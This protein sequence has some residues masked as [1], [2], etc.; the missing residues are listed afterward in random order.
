MSLV[1]NST[2]A[3]IGVQFVTGMIGV[4]AL[5]VPLPPEH[6]VLRDLLLLETVVQFVELT[7]YIVIVARF[8]LETMAATRYFDWVIT[9]PVML[10]TTVVF[11]AYSEVQEL[12][13][14][15]EHKASP[16]KLESFLKEPRNKRNLIAILGCNMGMLTFGY[17]GEIGVIPRAAAWLV[18]SVFFVGTFGILYTEYARKSVIGMRLFA[19]MF[20]IWSLYAVAYLLSSVHKNVMINGLDIVAKNLFGIFLAVAIF[21]EQGKA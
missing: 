8:H 21:R 11:M 18:S 15:Q 2:Y 9:T 1:L 19:A 4:A 17:L 7:A 10:L 12:S 20:G 13:K 5:F 6:A 14:V 3:S 16:I